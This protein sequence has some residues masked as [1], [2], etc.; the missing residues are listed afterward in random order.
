MMMMMTYGEDIER[1]F[2]YLQYMIQVTDFSDTQSW[3]MQ[4]YWD[5]EY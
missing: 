1:F 3:V 4:F 5:Q 2:N